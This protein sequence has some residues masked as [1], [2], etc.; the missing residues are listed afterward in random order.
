MIFVKSIPSDLNL[1]QFVSKLIIAGTNTACFN[2]Q[3]TE[4]FRI[5][6]NI[7]GL[8]DEFFCK[9][10]YSNSKQQRVIKIAVTID[11]TLK[12]TLKEANALY[13]WSAFHLSQSI[14]HLG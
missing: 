14:Q 3:R 8:N 13:F 9:H 7:S 1:Q 4:L 5:I 6:L 11:G 12:D 10:G 2:N